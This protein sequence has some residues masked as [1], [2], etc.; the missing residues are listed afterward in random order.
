MTFTCCSA[1]V[2]R[3]GKPPI[4]KAIVCTNNRGSS[5]GEGFCRLYCSWLAP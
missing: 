1:A 2:P 4:A 5:F 3:S